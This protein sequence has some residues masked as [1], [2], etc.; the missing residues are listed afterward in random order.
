[1]GSSE[2]TMKLLVYSLCVLL[3]SLTLVQGWCSYASGQAGNGGDAMVGYCVHDT[4]GANVIE[5]KEAC[6]ARCN[7]WTD[8]P[9]LGGHIYKEVDAV[10]IKD[11]CYCVYLK[12]S[13]NHAF[14]KTDPYCCTPSYEAENCDNAVCDE[15]GWC[16][17]GL[18]GPN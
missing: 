11:A 7:C 8:L 4:Y 1:M 13:C 16:H 18:L 17:H 2:Y 10:C 15:D 5:F 14:L 12:E 6:Y 3:Q 9:S